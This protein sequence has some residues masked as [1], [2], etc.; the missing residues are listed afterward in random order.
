MEAMHGLV[1]VSSC[2]DAV[3][4]GPAAQVTPVD[5]PRSSNSSTEGDMN[6]DLKGQSGTTSRV[7]ARDIPLP[8][9]L[10]YQPRKLGKNW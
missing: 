4:D 9:L 10:A 3:L 8:D 7:L 2:C 1:S 6:Q 5:G